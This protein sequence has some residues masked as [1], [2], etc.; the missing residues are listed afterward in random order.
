MHLE[1]KHASNKCTSSEHAT[2][3]CTTNKLAAIVITIASAHTGDEFAGAH[4]LYDFASAC[5]QFFC[6][7]YIYLFQTMNFHP[8]IACILQHTVIDR[9][10]IS[11]SSFWVYNELIGSR[12]IA[13]TIVVVTPIRYTDS[14]ALCRCKLRSGAIGSEDLCRCTMQCV[15]LHW[16]QPSICV[17]IN[18]CN[19]SKGSSTT[20]GEVAIVISAVLVLVLWDQKMMCRWS[21]G[22]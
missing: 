11:T 1:H 7:N 8:S 2:N 18:I 13:H 10:L 17:V 9:P 6:K 21:F 20:R 4:T 15:L 14:D 22:L 19:G 12:A 5:T 16:G 3:K